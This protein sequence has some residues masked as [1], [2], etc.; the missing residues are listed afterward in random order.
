MRCCARVLEISSDDHLSWNV[1]DPI[2]HALLHARLGDQRLDDHLIWNVHVLDK[3]R[4]E[5]RRRESLKSLD[6][7]V[8]SIVATMLG[9]GARCKTDS[10]S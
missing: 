9:R 6:I 4:R 2:D 5:G 1:H 8:V 3:L 7:M 10:E